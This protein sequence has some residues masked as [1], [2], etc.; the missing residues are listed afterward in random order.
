M[1]L[2]PLPQQLASLGAVL[3]LYRKNATG[4]LAG[5]SQAIRAACE[6][7]L[8]SDGLCE[9]L[10]FFDAEGDC[11]WQLYLL[12]DSDFLA[13]EHV[14]ADLPE[15]QPV[16]DHHGIAERLWRRL[17][18]RLGSPG[19]HANVLRFHAFVARPGVADMFMLAA[20]PARLSH[21]GA[22]VARRLL[23]NAGI[24]SSD[25]LDECCC[26]PVSANFA[27]LAEPAPLRQGALETRAYS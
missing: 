17:S 8:D 25:I 24:E 1:A 19:W 4:E 23:R 13:W 27:T 26:R 10:R 18:T 9:R 21:C 5:W 7:A 20:S 15:S 12:P 16:D 3:C 11:C 22:E 2:L 14:V 6:R